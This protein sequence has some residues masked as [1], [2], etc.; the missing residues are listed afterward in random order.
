MSEKIKKILFIDDD[1][2]IIGLYRMAFAKRDDF[3]FLVAEDS[4]EGEKMVKLEKPDLI[5][6]DLVFPKEEGL[7]TESGK[8]VQIRTHAG[9]KLLEKLKQD[10]ETKNIPIVVLTNLGDGGEDETKARDLGAFD[11]LVK[12]KFVPREVVEKV[13]EILKSLKSKQEK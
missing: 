3:Q 4:E 9:Y 1:K 8:V 11:Y 2:M 12:S 6:L 5:L 7:I 10:E 13:D